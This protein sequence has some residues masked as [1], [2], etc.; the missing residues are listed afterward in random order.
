MPVTYLR[1]EWHVY[2]AD[3]KE[4]FEF[5]SLVSDGEVVLMSRTLD[6]KKR[7]RLC[8]GPRLFVCVFV[9]FV[10]LFVCLF[11]LF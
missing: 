5:L 7:A 6:Y 11:A 9:L 2:D 3:L 1:T 4:D 10:C 8:F